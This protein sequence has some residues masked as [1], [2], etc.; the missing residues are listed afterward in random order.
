MFGRPSERQ[1][2]RPSVPREVQ[3]REYRKQAGDPSDG[4][5]A[6]PAVAPKVPEGRR[7]RRRRRHHSACRAQHLARP[8]RH[9]EDAGR[10]GPDRHLQRHGDAVRRPRQQD[11]RRPAADRVPGRRRGR[12][13]VQRDGRG[14]RRHPRRRPS[15]HR[16]LVRQEQDR[17]AVRHRPLLGLERRRGPRLDPPRRRP[18]AVQRDARDPRAERGRLLRDADAD[19]AARL[20]QGQDR[21]AG[22]PG[23]PEVPHG[24][25]RGRPVPEDG[26]RGRAAAGR[27]DPAGDGARRDRRVRIQQPDFRQP[28]RR[29]GRRQELHARART[30]RRPS[31]SRSSSTKTS[32]TRCRPSTRRSSNMRPRRRRPPI[33]RSASTTIRAIWSSCSRSTASASGA[34]RSRSSTRSSRRGTSCCPA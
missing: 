19:P 28:L 20:V 33:S 23:R 9:L 30:T 27:R 3:E 5:R 26:P 12:E 13:A 15:R 34:R 14:P 1:P 11:G 29:P 7:R 8:D 17:L 32:S 25:A 21:R 6:D 24:R 31:T 18:G 22:G 2:G 4:G 10:L 16:V